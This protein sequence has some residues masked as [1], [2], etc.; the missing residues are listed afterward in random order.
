[1]IWYG[2][3]Q[4]LWLV[5]ACIFI[6]ALL[7]FPT[8]ESNEQCTEEGEVYEYQDEEDQGQASQGKPSNLMHIWIPIYTFAYLLLL[9]ESAWIYIAIVRVAIICWLRLRESNCYHPSRWPPWL[10][11]LHPWT[12]GLLISNKALDKP[13]SG[14]KTLGMGTLKECL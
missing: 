9:Y 5:Y 8:I 11:I 13:S 6:C 14:A 7:F 12:S 4:C 1:M 10:P 2:V 3:L